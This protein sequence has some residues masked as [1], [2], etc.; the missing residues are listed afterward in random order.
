ME[1]FLRDAAERGWRRADRAWRRGNRHVRKLDTR[2]M[3]CRAVATAPADWLTAIRDQPEKLFTANLVQWCKRSGRHRVAEVALSSPTGPVRAFWK[4][5][6]EKNLVRK[7]LGRFRDSTVRHAWETG[8][9]FLRRGIATPKPLIYVEDHS[10]KTHRHYV[11]TEAIPNSITL[12]EFFATVHPQ[13]SKTDQHR[14]TLAVSRHLA[15]QLRRLHDCQ[16]DHRD[17][18]FGNI[19]VSTR[20][21]GPAQ[22]WLLDLDA[23]KQWPQLPASRAMQNLSRLNVSSLQGAAVNHA[24]RLRFLRWYLGDKFA[25]HWKSWWRNI[26]RRS[27][28]KQQQNL[29]RGRPLS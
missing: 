5:I 10:D 26:A 22:I 16:Y 20:D 4:C 29:Q 15:F 7:L 13:L 17:L 24:M 28:Q 27:R 18:K 23:V 14:R 2:T 1:F 11:L 25:A 3:R 9:A 12:H 21:E 19:L 6:E 8:H